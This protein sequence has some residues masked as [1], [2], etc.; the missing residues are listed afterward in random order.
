MNKEQMNFEE[1]LQVGKTYKIIYPYEDFLKK[2]QEEYHE[3]FEVV[4]INKK[5]I[6]HNLISGFYNPWVEYPLSEKR[7]K[8]S[9]L[10]EK[11]KD[12]YLIEVK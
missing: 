8:I 6:E 11:Y 4:K 2:E 7:T 1:F 5:T 3:V 10:K 9:R 12:G